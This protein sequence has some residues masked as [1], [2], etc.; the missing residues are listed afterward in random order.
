MSRPGAQRATADP[1][2][3]RVAGSGDFTQSG[4]R[5]PQDNPT[6]HTA[7]TVFEPANGP[8]LKDWLRDN[9]IEK[10]TVVQWTAGNTNTLPR[11]LPLSDFIQPE[12]LI[13]QKEM[14]LTAWVPNVNLPLSMQRVE[15][16]FLPDT[17]L[18]KTKLFVL[19][20]EPVDATQERKIFGCVRE[21]DQENQWIMD[22]I[23]QLVL[24]GHQIHGY[25]VPRYGYDIVERY[26]ANPPTSVRTQPAPTNS[27]NIS[28]SIVPTTIN[29]A[30]LY[31]GSTINPPPTSLAQELNDS[32]AQHG[33]APAAE[34][35]KRLK[36]EGRV[37]GRPEVK[38]ETP[39]TVNSGG[40]K[41]GKV[42][43]LNYVVR[44]STDCPLDM[45][46]R[47]PKARLV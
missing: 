39:R 15:L 9:P 17:S 24:R 33:M 41:V 32:K 19:G 7:N 23:T 22:G 14:P 6:D 31:S 18:M 46:L 20:P 44:F 27:T 35:Y 37:F 10:D 30:L 47:R 5:Q 8:W 34:A 40:S 11:R 1:N 21:N 29:G 42:K 28:N 38:V 12:E 4:N 16:M 26:P 2:S 45:D 13:D 36:L 3:A 25:V 43:K